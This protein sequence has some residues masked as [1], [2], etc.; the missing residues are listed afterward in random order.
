[1]VYG[2]SP[3]NRFFAKNIIRLKLPH[4]CIVNILKKER[5]FP[6]LIE[7]G[8]DPETIAKEI[9]C[10]ETNPAA[11]QKTVEGCR[12]V[13]ELLGSSSASQTAAQAILSQCATN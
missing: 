9:F 12:A 8:F 13:E 4:Y 6:E 10:L 1:M 2:L 5:V 7:Y 3:L 11:R